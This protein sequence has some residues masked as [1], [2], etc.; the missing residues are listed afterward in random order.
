MKPNEL[1]AV[2]A[3]VVGLC[4][5]L[6]GMVLLYESILSCFAFAQQKY[7]LMMLLLVFI[8]P[9]ILLLTGWWLL[10][11]TSWLV[12]KVYPRTIS[13]GETS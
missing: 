1:F 3:K 12:E 7:F 5:S 4:A 9:A 10:F 2:L 13:V 6:V 11:R 8:C